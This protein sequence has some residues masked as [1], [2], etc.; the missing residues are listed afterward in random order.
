M[1]D[2]PDVYLED[3]EPLDCEKVEMM[4]EE[5][6]EEFWRWATYICDFICDL[7]A[8]GLKNTEKYWEAVQNRV[9]ACRNLDFI[10]RELPA[11][12]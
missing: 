8:A 7:E 9:S 2:F 12:L 3:E 11:T 10:M 4:A 1:E 6:R 5:A